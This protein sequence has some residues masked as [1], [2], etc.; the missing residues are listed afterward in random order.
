MWFFTFLKSSVGKKIIMASTG[1]LLLLFICTHVIGNT[2][3]Y[4][5]SKYF[6]KYADALHSFP[7][8]VLL[9]SICLLLLVLTHAG[10]GIA[11]FLKNREE[12]NSRYAV[13]ARVVKNSLA[14][15][16]MAYSGIFIFLFL[17]IHVAGFSFRDDQVP[18]SI[19]V[20]DLLSGTFYG[21]F[22]II[23]FMIL[24]LHLSHGIWSMLQTFGI[25]HPQ[26]NWFIEKLTYILPVFFFLFFSGI[27]LYFMTGLGTNY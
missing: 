17:L 6:Q 20:Q 21:L 27:P 10:V 22:Y 25:N 15:K 7:L 12:G 19:L 9:F 2:T 14:S 13:S 18:I 4:M 16:T 1:L 3:I 11:L 23:S 8:L 26:Y 5:G 24:G